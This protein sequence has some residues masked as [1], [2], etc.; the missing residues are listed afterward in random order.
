MYNPLVGGVPL[1]PVPES[2]SSGN[3]TPTKVPKNAGAGRP[4]GAVSKASR[5]DIQRK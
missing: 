1:A 5:K 3:K 2:D 4:N